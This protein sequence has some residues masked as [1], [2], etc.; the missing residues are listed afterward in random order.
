LYLPFSHLPRFPKL[1]NFEIFRQQL[2]HLYTLVNRLISG[3]TYVDLYSAQ[4]VATPLTGTNGNLQVSSSL[5][6]DSVAQVW[7]KPKP[8]YISSITDSG[9]LACGTSTNIVSG[10][11]VVYQN[12][13]RSNYPDLAGFSHNRVYWVTS[14]DD[15][16]NSLKLSQ[17]YN[18]VN[19]YG[20]PLFDLGGTIAPKTEVLIPYTIDA[21]T[22]YSV[23][24]SS[25]GV[26]LYVLS[27]LSRKILQ[28]TLSTPE[29]IS[30]ASYLQTYTFAGGID[31]AA[32]NFS[33][34]GTKL[35]ITDDTGNRFSLYTMSSAWDISTLSDASNYLSFASET[36]GGR[37]TAIS[38][39]GAH[40]YVFKY[41]TGSYLV[42]QY[43]LS[44]PW[45]PSSGS[46]SG[47]SLDLG[48]T[49][50][51]GIEISGSGQRLLLV[52]RDTKHIREYKL[53]TP[54]DLST[55]VYYSSIYH[56]INDLYDLT[57]NLDQSRLYGY[58]RNNSPNTA[59]TVTTYFYNN[60]GGQHQLKFAQP[61][62]QIKEST[63]LPRNN[64]YPTPT[65]GNLAYGDVVQGTKANIYYMHN[66]NYRQVKL[67]W[68]GGNGYYNNN[69]TFAQKYTG[70][71]HGI[72]KY[73]IITSSNQI[74]V[75]F[76][77]M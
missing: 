76:D 22:D 29:D 18:G 17:Y 30:T 13:D 49:F 11:P 9:G 77:S 23:N 36:T 14:T 46:Y 59:G 62:T 52:N 64:T 70:W 4:S 33:P 8:F 48:T 24:F 75:I 61:L 26:Y 16:D 39:D 2:S 3:K 28:F 56:G 34:D 47:N 73:K 6:I 43:D 35:I 54:Y 45:S 10:M 44:T 55:A 21:S 20:T 72:G 7:N 66:G 38:N 42:Y 41:G 40:I 50:Y 69:T 53:T 15:T 63:Q 60:S 65:E 19:I 25:D 37:T 31:P 58:H 67:G 57:L 1:A 68:N 32:C 71:C 51:K 27:T 12:L 74:K 5:S